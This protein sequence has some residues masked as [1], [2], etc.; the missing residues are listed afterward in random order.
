MIT[1]SMGAVFGMHGG[2]DAM[3]E[4]DERLPLQMTASKFSFSKHC[5]IT[6]S[7]FLHFSLFFFLEIEIEIELLVLFFALSLLL[8]LWLVGWVGL[9]C[10]GLG[11]SVK[12]CIFSSNYMGLI[13]VEI[14]F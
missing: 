1:G 14:K 11:R 9:G 13:G 7:L 10:W 12:L 6:I 5:D 3:G 2:H 4:N 8:F